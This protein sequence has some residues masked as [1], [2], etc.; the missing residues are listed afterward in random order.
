MKN[1]LLL[2]LLFSFCC[3][4]YAQVRTA[5]QLYQDVSS[6]A[7]EEYNSKITSYMRV[8]ADHVT[9]DK[10]GYTFKMSLIAFKNQQK[11]DDIEFLKRI[12]R[13]LRYAE[14]SG[15]VSFNKQQ[16]INN[17]NAGA[18]FTLL[19]RRDTAVYVFKNKIAQ[20]TV[21]DIMRNASRNYIN[22]LIEKK[23]KTLTEADSIAGV[24]MNTVNFVGGHAVSEVDAD[25]IPFL[26]QESRL[27]T[28]LTF[29]EFYQVMYDDFDKF[30]KTVQRR[31]LWTLFPSLSYN[32]LESGWE[33]IGGGSEFLVSLGKDVNKKPWELVARLS[34]YQ[35]NDTATK[36]INLNSKTGSFSLGINKV[37]LENSQ[38][39]SQMELKF[40]SEFPHNFSKAATQKNPTLNLDFKYKLFQSV[41]L[42]ITIS[43]DPERGNLAGFLNITMNLNPNN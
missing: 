39:E 32:Y 1:L 3:K 13:F 18:V 4:S 2:F 19:N 38:G 35:E 26:N 21:Q 34:Y 22:F 10:S 31:P 25:F 37:L 8:V 9:S 12:N 33:K 24:S 15:G 28:G 36:K 6:H 42:P 30:S 27:Q 11:L 23:G 7:T 41:W 43:Y 40:S 29:P 16:K 20:I 14:V 17:I 5:W